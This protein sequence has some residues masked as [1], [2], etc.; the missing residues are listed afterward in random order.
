[1]LSPALT[2]AME[3]SRKLIINKLFFILVWSKGKNSVVAILS[4]GY[5]VEL[6]PI[7]VGFCG[8]VVMNM[9]MNT[10]EKSWEIVEVTAECLAY[11][12]VEL[13]AEGR[14]MHHDHRAVET[15]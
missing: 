14:G 9:T 15:G 6:Q 12:V 1:M 5:T 3:I 8:I 2:L 11:I 10:A 4:T 7:T 13:V